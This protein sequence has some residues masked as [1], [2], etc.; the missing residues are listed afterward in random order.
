M[1]IMK[2]PA[3]RAPNSVKRAICFQC[4]ADLHSATPRVPEGETRLCKHC[5]FA[6]LT[7]PVGQKIVPTEIWCLRHQAAR[8]A[9]GF[10]QECFECAFTWRRE[11]SLD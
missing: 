4:E 10:A 3:C 8:A 5:S 6:A 11:E 7:P 1:Q 2:C 9:D